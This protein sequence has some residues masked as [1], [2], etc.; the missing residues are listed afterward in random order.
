MDM[1]PDQKS[2]YADWWGLITH[3]GSARNQQGGYAYSTTD[4]QTAV[5]EI[6]RAAGQ[7]ITFAA[8]SFVSKLFG[9]SRGIERSADTLTAAPNEAAITAAMVSEP[10]WSR[11]LR[12]QTAAPQ[13]QLRAEITYRAPDGSIVTTWGTGIFNYVLPSTAGAMRDEAFLQFSRMLSRRNDLKNTGGELLDIGRQYL[14]A[15]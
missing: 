6:L 10:P 11:P 7:T 9:V 15:V 4:L 2:T 14:M 5:T 13:W 8:R 3:A 1:T 12:V